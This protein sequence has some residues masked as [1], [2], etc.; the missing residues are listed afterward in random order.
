[1]SAQVHVVA[2]ITPAAGK[3]SR[4]GFGGRMGIDGVLTVNLVGERSSHEP[5]EPRQGK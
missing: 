4:V 5:R 3:E 1:M 2:I